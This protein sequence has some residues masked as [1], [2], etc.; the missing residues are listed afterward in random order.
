MKTLIQQTV[1]LVIILIATS[2]CTKND[3]PLPVATPPVMTNISISGENLV[4]NITIFFNEGVYAN[5]NKTGDLTR[6][7]LSLGINSQE[8]LISSY[9]VTHS[10]C[11]KN[12]NIRIVLNRKPVDNEIIFI[13]P[14]TCLSIYN[15]DGIAM[16]TSEELS[17]AIADN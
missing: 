14:A 12:A 16:C 5:K 8:I 1:I 10:A 7:S 3:N 17:I 11:Q 2:S 15:F 4:Y 13:Q 9:I 6:N